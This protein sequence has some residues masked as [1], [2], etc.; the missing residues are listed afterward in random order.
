MPG[1][2]LAFACGVQ[3]GCGQ[4]PVCADFVLCAGHYSGVFGVDP[5]DTTAYEPDG[6]CWTDPFV[7]Q[8]CEE[9]CEDTRAAYRQT[10]EEAEQ[11]VGACDEAIST[12]GGS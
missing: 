8:A 1:L 6:S 9:Q 2:L 12:D 3:T 7:A 5:P 10:L 11:D 4:S